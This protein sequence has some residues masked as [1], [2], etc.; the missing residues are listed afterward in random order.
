MR[1]NNEAYLDNSATTRVYPEVIENMKR[2]MGEEYGN[3][4]SLHRKG[5]AAERILHGAREELAELL[6][7]KGKSL[8]FTSGGTESNNLAVLGIARR[9][10]RRGN[11]LVT[12]AVEHS[13]VLEPCKRLEK[14]GF[15]VTYVSPDAR[16]LVDPDAVMEALTPE[17]VLLSVMHANNETGAIMPLSRLA[18]V[19]K[20]QNPGVVFHVDAAQSMTKLPLAPEALMIDAVSLSA[21][22]FHGPK[23]VGA[24]YLREGLLVEPLFGG[25]GQQG[26][27]RPGTE[28]TPGILGMALAARQG[29]EH[30]CRDQDRIRGY[31]NK[32]ITRLQ[33]ACPQCRIIGPEGSHV[34]PHILNVSFPGLKG[35]VILH[36][37]EE[38]HIFVSTGSA[39][40]AR[41]KEPSHVLRAMGLEQ[42]ILEG[43]VR[44][45]FSWLNTEEEIEFVA[46]KMPA[47]IKE[48]YAFFQ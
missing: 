26:E 6:G 23:G 45:S 44:I 10:R 7:V 43:A 25:G 41:S 28:N 31:R 32:M 11:H 24:L 22:K 46:E 29:M 14:E 38:Y 2:I 27:I 33:Q 1:T 21:H 37:L 40:H 9:H 20:D 12:T 15:R 30:Y 18:R 3:P 47:V 48:L 4:S 36:A 16:G 34:A 19:V 8:F 42:E 39:C 5:T 13:S 17:T 35:E